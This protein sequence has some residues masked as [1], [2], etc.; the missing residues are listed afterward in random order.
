MQTSELDLDA[1]E[2][3]DESTE[4][5][6]GQAMARWRLRSIKRYSAPAKEALG[7]REKGLA[8][9]RGITDSERATITQCFREF[10]EDD[11][12]ALEIGEVALLF[13]SVYGL[14]PTR[15]QL[16]K[17]MRE[18]DTDGN[19]VVDLEEFI[20]A[21]AT[22]PEVTMAGE[23]FKVKWLFEKYDTDNS[24]ELSGGELKQLVAEAW[25]QEADT[26]AIEALIEDADEDGNGEVSWDEFCDM[27][28]RCR[29]QIGM[30][31]LSH[32]IPAAGPGLDIDHDCGYEQSHGHAGE[33]VVS[34]A[35]HVS[36]GD[37]RVKEPV[38]EREHE[39]G[40]DD[41]DGGDGDGD[42]EGEGGHG[43]GHG[44]ALGENISDEPGAPCQTGLPTTIS[45]S[46]PQLRS[47]NPKSTS[48]LAGDNDST[49]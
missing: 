43:H 15:K 11:T 23:A 17:L 1:W 12:G 45:E 29:G 49:Q 20:A 27:I 33:P 8:F 44:H 25:G 47:P 41:G 34:T 48:M 4:I 22:V 36:I 38:C 18:I 13:K 10:D 9:L 24:G 14:Q 21:M 16:E 7:V 30:H 39:H 40:R 2:G 31:D 26:R 6:L 37:T 3:Y 46:L 35:L 5:V 32:T 19:G 42:S 28:T